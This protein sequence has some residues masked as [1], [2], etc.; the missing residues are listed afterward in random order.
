L[1]LES[2][3]QLALQLA[4]YGFRPVFYFEICCPTDGT[5]RLC[6]ESWQANE[7][8]LCPSCQQTCATSPLLCRAFM[9]QEL[10][11]P[12]ATNGS[13]RSCGAKVASGDG[14]FASH[15]QGEAQTK[16]VQAATGLE[17]HSCE[18]PAGTVNKERFALF[19]EW[20]FPCPQAG[21]AR[22]AVFLGNETLALER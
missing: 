9:R 5:W 4:E 17:S 2:W 7:S 1:A 18:T 3:D 16:A 6:L 22:S 13:S 14:R 15:D 19:Q 12:R 10:P 8:A 11:K 20:H 21:T